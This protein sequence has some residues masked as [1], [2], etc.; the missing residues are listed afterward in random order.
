MKFIIAGD[1][2]WRGT[3]PRAR[4]DDYMLALGK[5][6]EEVARLCKNYGAPLI[7]PGD[8][9]DSPSITWW[10]VGQLI[11]K[12]RATNR[13]VLTVPGNHDIFGSNLDSVMRTPCGLMEY[14]G[15][16]WNV[17]RGAFV[18]PAGGGNVAVTGHGY[19]ADTDTEAGAY[20][21]IAPEPK[22]DYAPA[23][24]AVKIH[25]VHSNLM[26]DP[27][28]FDS[29]P[30]TLISD[31][32][33]NADVIISGHYHPGFGIYRRD[34]GVLFINPGALART[35]AGAS[36][37]SRQVGVVLLTVHPDGKCGAEWIPLSSA[38]PGEEVLSREHLDDAAERASR[39]QDFL[40]L[41]AE[42]GQSRFLEMS[43]IIEDISERDR[44]PKEIKAEALKRLSLAQEALG[45]GKW[46][47]QSM[48]LP[49]PLSK[50][51]PNA[52]ETR[53]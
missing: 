50:A 24:A 21:F 16:I 38:L 35:S 44:L 9:V 1:L 25:L 43:E 31:V 48:A 40:E 8:L 7:I 26:V 33:T 34:D 29:M 14:I 3:N 49:E 13:P 32:K 51:S 15:V 11:N 36:D 2:H 37:M 22:G 47:A 20:Q 45:V 52:G 19:N 53:S 30:H 18:I 41:L 4:R 12:L 39:I 27:P 42:E 10:V 17:S 23:P 5:K 46:I 28:G 6:L